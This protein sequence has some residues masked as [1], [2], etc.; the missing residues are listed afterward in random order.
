MQRVDQWLVELKQWFSSGA[1]DEACS[2]VSPLASARQWL[3]PVLGGCELSATFTVRSDKVG[4]AECA[5]GLRPVLL[6]TRPEIASGKPAKTA[7]RPHPFAL[8]R[9]KISLTL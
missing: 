5:D 8:K 3:V 2:E 6:H 9:V 7:G 4:I 1:D